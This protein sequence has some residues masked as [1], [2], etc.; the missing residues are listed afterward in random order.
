M[1]ESR[2]NRI[3]QQSQDSARSSVSGGQPSR[4]TLTAILSMKIEEDNSEEAQRARR[5]A[6][7]AKRLQE[8]N[9]SKAGEVLGS[10]REDTTS[11]IQD[12]DI[13]TIDPSALKRVAA[14]KEAQKEVAGMFENV[15]KDVAKLVQA[16]S[17]Q[18]PRTNPSENGGTS[19]LISEKTA[20]DVAPVLTVI[21]KLRTGSMSAEQ[22][23]RVSEIRSIE[24]SLR[25]EQAKIAFRS[26]TTRLQL[27]ELLDVLGNLNTNVDREHLQ[28]VTMLWKRWLFKWNTR[29]RVIVCE[30]KAN[31]QKLVGIFVVLEEEYE[32]MMRGGSTPPANSLRPPVSPSQ[33]PRYDSVHNGIVVIQRYRPG[34]RWLPLQPPVGDLASPSS[35]HFAAVHFPVE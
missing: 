9:S 22:Q 25:H 15:Q 23:A 11:A 19:V 10:S 18:Q 31:I 7:R 8:K 32:R 2:V 16:E 35:K 33:D 34:S 4:D 17:Q 12:S 30:R 24:K 3:L 21:N 5:R 27:R 29:R 6:A 26:L 28:K 14:T 1:P 13:T 20:E